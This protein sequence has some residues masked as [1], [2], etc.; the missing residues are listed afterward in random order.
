MALAIKILLFLLAFLLQ[1][2]LIGNTKFN[3]RLLKIYIISKCSKIAFIA[4]L[5][6][7]QT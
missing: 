3:T 6:H 2:H 4:M 5:V 1:T 7:Q